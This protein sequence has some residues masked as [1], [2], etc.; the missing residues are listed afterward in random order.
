M[1]LKV[2]ILTNLKNKQKQIFTLIQK[3]FIQ[4]IL[5]LQELVEI[6]IK[7]KMQFFKLFHLLTPN[8]K[9]FIINIKVNLIHKINLMNLNLL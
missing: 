5:E 1:G 9:D 8:F 2:S 4:E 7:L 3:L 6:L